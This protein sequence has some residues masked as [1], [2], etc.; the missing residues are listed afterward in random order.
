MNTRYCTRCFIYYKGKVALSILDKVSEPKV[1]HF[2]SSHRLI[3]EFR[4]RSS[5]SK[6][7]ALSPYAVSLFYPKPLNIR[8]YLKRHS[9]NLK[10]CFS[11]RYCRENAILSY[12]LPAIS[13]QPTDTWAPGTEDDEKTRHNWCLSWLCG[14][15]SGQER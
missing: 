9:C 8:R 5:D 3:S 13:F 2:T 15:V 7:Q 11:G 12:I 14:L 6:A 1:K 4:L 10:Y